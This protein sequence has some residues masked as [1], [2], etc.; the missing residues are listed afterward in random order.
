MY[1]GTTDTTDTHTAPDTPPGTV[2]P[3]VGPVPIPSP[4]SPSSGGTWPLAHHPTAPRTARQIVATVLKGWRLD[5]QS[6]DTVLLVVSELVTNAIEHAQPPVALHLH[7]EHVGDRVWVGL[8]DG[9]PAPTHG[10]WTTTCAPEEHGRGLDIIDTLAHSH[11]THTHNTGTTHWAR[12][13][14]RG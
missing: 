8:T 14:I 5:E 13:T 3:P 9:G 11:G 1:L 2:R 10:A 6:A 7:R 4:R 12:L